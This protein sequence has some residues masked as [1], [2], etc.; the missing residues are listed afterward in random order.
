MSTFSCVFVNHA[1]TVMQQLLL[2]LNLIL[3]DSALES[4]HLMNNGKFNPGLAC[5]TWMQFTHEEDDEYSLF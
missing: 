4:I 1:F 3:S 5:S 2:S